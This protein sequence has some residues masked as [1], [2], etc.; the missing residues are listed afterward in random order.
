[1]TRIIRAALWLPLLTAS[2]WSQSIS[3]SLVGSIVDSGDAP[4][5][6]ATVV[7]TAEATGTA[8]QATTN[9]K[10]E[11]DF[12]SLRPGAY[13]LRVSVTG[14][15]T[16]EKTSIQIPASERVSAGL[17]KLELGAVTEQITVS[18]QGAQVQTASAERG[19]V[20]TN[21]QVDNLL[22]KGRTVTS[23][24]GLLP[25]IVDETPSDRIQRNW[26]ISSLGGRSGAN[27][28]WI[29]GM[30][31]NASN[32]TNAVVGISMDAV[33]EVKV[34]QGNYQAEYGRMLGANIQI[35]S[36]SGSRDFHGSAAYY[37]R[38][39]Q[40][41]ANN[42]FN[43]QL[44][45]PKPKYRYN[46]WTYSLGGP[47]IIPKLLNGRDKL[48]FFF[49]QE[50]WPISVTQPTGR[51]TV[52]T[53][54]ERAGDFSQTVD[55][56]RVLIPIKDPTTGQTFPGN[57][58]PANRLDASGVALLKVFPLP[59]FSNT[60][61]S[62]GQYN[63]VFQTG[64]KLPQR[65]ETLRLDYNLTP[66]NLFNGTFTQYSDVQDGSQGIATSAGNW[67]QM[68][69]RFSTPGRV[70]ILKYQRIFSPTLVNELNLGYTNRP[71]FDEASTPEDLSRNQRDKIGFT[72]GQLSPGINPLNI[73]PNATFGG[74]TGAANLSVEGRFPLF[75]TLKMISVT[76]NLTKTIGAHTVKAGLYFDQAL[77]GVKIGGAYNGAIDFSRNVNNPLDTNFAY[78]NAAL[79]NYSTYSEMSNRPW[80][81][82]K[83]IN[84][85]WFVQDNWRVTRRLTLDFGVRFSHFPAVSERNNQIAGFAASLYD[86]AQQVRLIVPAIVNGARV[87]IDRV[88]QRV[89]PPAVIGGIV[90]GSGN[91][92]NGIV[93]GRNSGS[94]P[95]TLMNDP[96]VNFGPRFGFAYD[97]FGDG[98]TAIR[99]GF[100]IVHQ[101]LNPSPNGLT[102][103]TPIVETPVLYYGAISSLRGQ[104]AYLFPQAATG[105]DVNHGIPQVMNFSFSVQ[106][107]VG[108]GTVVDVAY[109]GSLGRHLLW[110]QLF[111]E[112]PIG[113]NFNPANADPTNASV[114]LPAVFL[115]P[116]AGFNNISIERA[117]SSSNYHSL[118]ITAN[119]RFAKGLQIGTSYTWSKSLDYGTT[120]SGLTSAKWNYGLTSLDRT[121]VLKLNWQYQI[122]SLARAPR[123]VGW[124]T[125]NWQISGITTFSSG[126]P[127]SV[128]FTTT[129][130]IDITG[131]ASATARIVVL[132]D[133]NLPRGERTFDRNF[134]TNVFARPAQGTL[135][136]S[137]PTII[138]G[139]G[140]NNWDLALFKSFPIRERLSL[141]F[142]AEAYNAF[143][144]T[145]FSS[146]DTTARFDAQGAQINTRLGAFI[147]ARDPRIMQF[148]IRVSF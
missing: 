29:D 102:T 62:A 119:R 131:S 51:V 41:N 19:G 129:N 9:A 78:S 46:T 12:N 93:D 146:L 107:D 144:H 54:L 23:L 28:V 130:G 108:F 15:K 124:V 112:V 126:Q 115:R 69:K 141:Q 116:L 94:Y 26:N 111:N 103:Q 114:P 18:S 71:E 63:Y 60:A 148:A 137:A 58:I 34:L 53:E 2:V 127:L 13:S 89:F 72:A 37:K 70:Y 61:V 57:R 85:E 38:H 86:P 40:F 136:N 145:Q 113:A 80:T 11:F 10:G 81:V 106:R 42:F 143:N 36:R 132:S 122:P 74:V 147:A 98:K 59:N 123:P 109:V 65:T 47:V 97:V 73:I 14:F 125:N 8:R 49:N 24:L 67:P 33:A 30:S 45:Q 31:M 1:M 44:R 96:G 25:G 121:H 110:N 99:G 82:W 48:F 120:L 7:L 68:A 117:D 92:A 100:G 55:L 4:V 16:F 3:G 134:R 135:G 79:G 88:T 105:Y 21:K 77:R 27:N 20:I 128:G 39:E 75:G 142:R 66:R 90:P 133:P 138:R 17:L 87:G 91:P 6:A 118:Q 140:V 104:G 22:I 50:I 84:L 52:P 83:A 35:I 76:D 95:K 56:N 32:N 139:P 43:N 64:T 101:A 5:A